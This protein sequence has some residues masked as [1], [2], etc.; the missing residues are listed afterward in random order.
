[1]FSLFTA[2][3]FSVYAAELDTEQIGAK[4]ESA[5]IGYYEYSTFN[6]RLN[7][8]KNNYPH[9][10]YSN[11]QAPAGWYECWAYANKVTYEIFGSYGYQWSHHQDRSYIYPGDLIRYGGYYG[12]GHSIVVTA[13][14]G[15]TIYYTDR[16]GTSNYNM[17]RWG[18]SINRWDI[19]FVAGDSGRQ[20]IYHAP[21]WDSVIPWINPNPPSNAWLSASTDLIPPGGSVSFSFGAD[22]ATDYY[23]GIDLNGSRLISEGTWEGLWSGKSFTFTEPGNYSVVVSASN[24]AGWV[25]SNWVNF[26][27][28]PQGYVMTD[29][30]GAGQTIPDG[31]Y[32]IC[33]KIAQDYFVDIP[34]TDY[35]T[36]NETN[37]EMCK[38]FVGAETNTKYDVFTFKYLNNGYYKITQMTTSMA[39][40]VT[41]GS[42]YRETNVQMYKYNGTDAQQWSVEKTDA[43]YKLRA[44]CNNYYLDVYGGNYESGTNLHVWT[45][46][47]TSAQYFGLIPYAPDEKPIKDGIYSIKSAVGDTSYMD[48]A[49][50]PGEYKND[51]N[52]QIYNWNEPEE[53]YKFEYVGDGYYRIYEASTN[54]AVEI[55]NDNVSY[56]DKNKN[57]KLYSKNDSRGQFWKIKQNSDGTYFFI[58]KLS[59]YYLDVCDGKKDNGTNIHIHPYNGSNAQRWTPRRVISDDMVT[60]NDVVTNSDATSVSPSVTVKVDGSAI[61][62]KFY[63]VKTEADIANGTGTVTIT[64]KDTYCGSVTKSF[65]ITIN[66]TTVI[67]DFVGNKYNTEK[68]DII[69]YYLNLSPPNAIN[70]LNGTIYYNKEVLSP[71]MSYYT[72]F[73]APSFDHA[74]FRLR[75]PGEVE[76]DLYND[77][78]KICKNNSTIV[79]MQFRVIKKG[80][81]SWLGNDF[82]TDGYDWNSLIAYGM[83]PHILTN[84]KI[85]SPVGDANN[86]G[87]IDVLDATIVQKHASGKA[88]LTDEQ[89]AIADVNNDGVADI[90]DAAEIQKFA[91]GKITEFKKKA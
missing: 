10:S 30:E 9:G 65:N 20:G 14:D 4:D 69:T 17:V 38:G 16:N 2:L 58:N 51:S 21:N 61:N 15:D 47:D 81:E 57:A 75:T 55:I 6:A 56:L 19:Y 11:W 85:Y 88:D 66:D 78:P 67:N 49:G 84:Q 31:D 90:L 37:L 52:I 59:G 76:F 25:N 43:G 74:N 23:L 48:A 68:G 73:N 53:K 26:R 32:W 50:E 62:S 71:I 28:V 46:N 27:V 41:G 29:A 22:G 60:V 5:G 64:G 91:A 86:D 12:T 34:G 7:N 77:N 54:L 70:Y 82:S 1:M 40:D 13:V 42:L 39:I 79:K 3:P 80:G 89:R 33:S 8:C 44:R 24:S 72:E 36:K 87:K 45:A 63:S 18:A 35:N 83:E